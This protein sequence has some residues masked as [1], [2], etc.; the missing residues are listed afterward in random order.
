MNRP[1]NEPE[2]GGLSQ[3][4]S[5][6]QVAQAL[7]VS[8][9]TVK[10]WVD[11]GILPAY[12]TPGGHRKLSMA[13]VLMAVRQGNLPQADLS[14][15]IPTRGQTSNDTEYLVRQFQLAVSDVDGE[16]MRAILHGAYLAGVSIPTLADK[17][18]APVMVQVGEDWHSGKIDVSVEH[19]IS[20]A[21]MTALYGL[22]AMLKTTTA[23]DRPVAIGG[24]PENDHAATASLLAKLT[25]L[26]GG[27]NAIN[28]GPH[29]PAFA[30]RKAIDDL[31]PTL[32]WM[33]VTHLMQPDQFVADYTTLYNAAYSR[34]ISVAIG[35]RGLTDQLRKRLPYTTFG[36]GFEHLAAFAR[37]LHR[38]PARGQRGRPTRNKSGTSD[39]GEIPSLN[40][41][42][43]ETDNH[44]NNTNGYHN[45][46]NRWDHDERL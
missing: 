15:L 46:G 19:R 6:A 21:C 10:R 5:T 25:L 20:Q 17:V 29:T 4:V 1:N 7:G 9:T 35:G 30:F 40:N 18:I 45:N 23:D 28:L 24:A 8:V 16:Q 37:S 33:T 3:H 13:D 32:I 39:S 41:G 42:N 26:E 34:G 38:R 12:R 36:D 2:E 22:Q 44:T 11:E 43:G 27:W 14:K 31:K